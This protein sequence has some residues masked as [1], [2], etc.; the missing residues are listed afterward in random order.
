MFDKAWYLTKNP[1]VLASGMDPVR[2]YIEFGA[3]EGRDPSPSFSTT[4]YL[5]HN[6]DVAS[7]G[8]NPLIHYILYAA[9]EGR[10]AKCAAGSLD[11]AAQPPHGINWPPPVVMIIYTVYP[12]PDQDADSVDA[13]N[14]VRI[15]RDLGYQVAFAA[16]EFSVL[17]HYRARLRRQHAGGNSKPM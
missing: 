11:K 2:Y 15:F 12:S 6:L 9:K 13:L 4:Y 14:Y 1:D 7:A 16:A 10:T 17:S 8:V 3:R 5:T